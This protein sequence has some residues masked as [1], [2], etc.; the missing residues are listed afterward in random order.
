[1][2]QPLVQMKRFKSVSPAGLGIAKNGKYQ[3]PYKF[4][5]NLIQS[6]QMPPRTSAYGFLWP[7]V[8]DFVA[9]AIP[10]GIL[11]AGTVGKVISTDYSSAH[12]SVKLMK[13]DGSADGAW[14]YA[15]CPMTREQVKEVHDFYA[16]RPER[17]GVEWFR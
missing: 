6:G 4:Q 16:D 3:L 12:P 9:A 8:G 7:E 13:L 1:M 17:I 14:A 2:T 15:L 10:S 11:S 5:A